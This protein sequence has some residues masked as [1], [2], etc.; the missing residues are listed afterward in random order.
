MDREQ[1][2]SPLDPPSKGD[3]RDLPEE[4]DDEDTESGEQLT[5]HAPESVVERIASIEIEAI[6]GGALQRISFR[7]GTNPGE[8]KA[9]LLS[10]DAGA[11]VRDEFPMK[12]FGNRDT[13]SARARVINARV[14]DSG[15]FVDLICQ[16]GEDLSVSVS[17][18]HAETFLADIGALNKLREKSLAK[19]AKAFDE[20]SA[21]TI[22]LDADEQF[23]VKY[24][25]TDD[26]K[27]FLDSMT[28]EAPAPGEE[29][30]DE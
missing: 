15:K 9:M 28:A 12:R 4:D 2:G 11:K 17:K 29:K 24:W 16:N 6:V 3:G 1:R 7:A 5:L 26:G 27:A 22:I 13:K 8:V 18:K 21:A 14:T 30:S 19:L 25:T 20:K 10:I 23:G